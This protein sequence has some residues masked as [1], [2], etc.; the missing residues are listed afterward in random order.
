M[1]SSNLSKLEIPHDLSKLEDE[2]FENL[3]LHHKRALIRINSGT[4]S[5]KVL[6]RRDREHLSKLGIIT[7]AKS[8]GKRYTLTPKA[9]KILGIQI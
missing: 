4:A 2:S 5:G 1:R 6:S 8:H 7:F 3:V 9:K